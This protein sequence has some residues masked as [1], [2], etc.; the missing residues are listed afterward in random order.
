MYE[1]RQHILFKYPIK[2]KAWYL[3][4]LNTTHV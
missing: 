4:K 1:I 2:S 3:N